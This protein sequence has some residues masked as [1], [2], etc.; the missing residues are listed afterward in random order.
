MELVEVEKPKEGTDG[1][2]DC[3]GKEREG[4]LSDDPIR[5]TAEDVRE[6]YWKTR[7]AHYPAA[8]LQ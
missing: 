3:S 7:G 2:A 8:S 6:E 5:M 1:S 4:G